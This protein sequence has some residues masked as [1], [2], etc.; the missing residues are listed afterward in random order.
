MRAPLDPRPYGVPMQPTGPGA[1]QV[2]L[3]TV[4]TICAG[5]LAVAAAVVFLLRTQ[6]ALTL[7]IGA[8]MLAIGMDHA[9]APLARR[10]LPR[11]WAVPLVVLLV[12]AL[13]AGLGLLLAPPLLGQAKAF[14]AAAPAIWERLQQTPLFLALDV[15]FDLKEKLQESMPAAAG[16]LKP[17]LGA[18]GGALSLAAGLL[19]LLLLAVFMLIFGGDLVAALLAEAAEP[20]RARFQAVASKVYRSVGGYVAGVAAI[21]GI[22]ATATTLFLALTGMPF[23]LPLGILSGV[24]SAVP[25]AGPLVTCVVISLLALATGGP[26]KALATGLFFFLY[27]QLEGSVVSPLVFRRTVHVSPLLVT[28]AILFMAEF[29]G[30]PGALLAVPAVAVA[31]ILVR[32]LLALRREQ[33]ATA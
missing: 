33:A 32:E 19:S 16:A 7:A 11:K 15:R 14:T 1:S 23:F 2:T 18:I 17:L 9:V 22:N 8:A 25:Y 31:Q 28:L 20:N 30:L 10:G 3:R 12:V 26:V 27:G 13:G 4:F 5:V 21:G 29:M 24:S 6:V